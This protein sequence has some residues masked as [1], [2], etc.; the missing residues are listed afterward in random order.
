MQSSGYVKQIQKRITENETRNLYHKIVSL[1]VFTGSEL[2]NST[3]FALKDQRIN[4]LGVF[5]RTFYKGW[6]DTRA[7]PMLRSNIAVL[8]SHDVPTSLF[9]LVNLCLDYAANS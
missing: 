6:R 9:F 2:K 3:L 4:F 1:L 5:M 7:T 8:P